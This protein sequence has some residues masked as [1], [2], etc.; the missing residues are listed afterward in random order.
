MNRRQFLAGLAAAPLARAQARCG[1][2]LSPDSF[3][4]RRPAR[5]ALE[6]LELTR[7]VG[8]GGVQATLASNDP[9]YLKRVRQRVE[10]WDMYLEL[11][12]GLRGEGDA[13]RFEA[14]VKSAREAGA[15]AMRFVCLSGRR[16]E[17]FN[18]L[19][20]W[21]AF[22]AESRKRM[23]IVARIAEKH[24]VPLG[25]ENHKDWTLEE[26]VPLMREFGGEYVG[27]CIDF[28][29]N[30]SLLDDPAEVVEQLAPFAVNAHIKDMAVERYPDGFL[31]S[32]VPLGEGYLD[33]KRL[34]A[35]VLKA[36]PKINFSLDMLTRDPL[37][38]PCLTEKYWA[39]FPERN[40]K[41]LARTLATVQAQQR[42]T[43]LQRLGGLDKEAQLRLE[44]ENVTKSVAYA[45]DHLGLV[46]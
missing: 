29:N 6:F 26:M 25:I 18:T 33:L 8:A 19:E 16:Y 27:A 43:P 45:R 22:V 9:E 21:R 11:M 40:G 13:E 42:P 2:G 32:E 44:M 1:M 38:I 4:I 39:T 5:T 36:R 41:Y 28:G 17:N 31:L 10:E 46:R 30:I 34:V 20:E 35:T 12:V 7:S 23:T 14:T 37:K 15:Q 3:V 24:R